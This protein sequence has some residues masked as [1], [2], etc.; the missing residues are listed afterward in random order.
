MRIGHVRDAF[1]LVWWMTN[2]THFS[3]VLVLLAFASRMNVMY[4]NVIVTFLDR[5]S[6]MIHVAACKSSVTA[7]QMTQLFITSVVR[8]CGP[9]TLCKGHFKL[10]V[11]WDGE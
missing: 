6:K 1:H 8:H 2:I 11:P 9:H 4:C 5:F 7:E 10:R 3:F